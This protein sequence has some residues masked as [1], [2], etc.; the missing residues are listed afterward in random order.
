MWWNTNV[1]KTEYII[2][3]DIGE[4][5]QEVNGTKNAIKII[6]DGKGEVRI[7]KY[8]GFFVQKD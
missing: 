8:L 4:R 1:R 6:G 5:D 7:F 2:E 3:Y